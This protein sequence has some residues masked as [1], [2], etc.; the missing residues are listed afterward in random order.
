MSLFNGVRKKDICLLRR[1]GFFLR[2]A[3]E[4]VLTEIFY[5]G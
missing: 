5:L 1:V 4:I 2:G 3:T